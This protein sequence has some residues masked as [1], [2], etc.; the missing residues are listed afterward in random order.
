[1]GIELPIVLGLVSIIYLLFFYKTENRIL[2]IIFL[3]AIFSNILLM[4]SQDIVVIAFFINSMF[5]A[6]FLLIF[7]I[8]Y[9]KDIVDMISKVI[10]TLKKKNY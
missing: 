1:M 4:F 8:F 10:K 2:K 5:F 7:L 6:F 3:F 9:L